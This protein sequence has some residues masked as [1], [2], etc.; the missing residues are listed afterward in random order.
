M[1]IVSGTRTNFI[2]LTAVLGLV[3]TVAKARVPVH[4]LFVR[5]ALIGLFVTALIPALGQVLTSDRGVFAARIQ[6]LE[7][8]LSGDFASDAS[9]QERAQSYAVAKSAFMDSPWFG[10]GPGHPFP[11]GQS[12]RGS[13]ASLDTP[14][15]VAAKF[16]LIGLTAI[17]LYLVSALMCMTAIRR[18]FGWQEMLTVGRGWTVT[19]LFLLPFGPWIGGQGVC[20]ST[21]PLPS[22]TGHDGAHEKCA[23]VGASG[24]CLRV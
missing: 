24:T 1:M 5:V 12:L 9:F 18:Q 13:S 7:A 16:G 11:S 14:W 19:L 22:S 17:L 6:S 21:R 2:L 15:L 20:L 3:G 10:V 8:V 4:G 23:G